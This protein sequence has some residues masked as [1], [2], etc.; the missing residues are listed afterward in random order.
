MRVISQAFQEISPADFFYRNREIAGFSNPS[1]AVFSAIRE[2][3]ENSLDATE[4]FGILPDIYI[5][6]SSTSN[7][8]VEEG[9][10]SL[11]VED[12]GIGIPGEHI[13]HAFC[14]FLFSSKYR[15]R[16][17]RG[18]FGL[19]GTMA[20]LYGQ[21][22]TN[23]PVRV[24]SSTGDQ[25]IYEF[26]LM[27]DIER[28]RPIILGKKT[29]NNDEQWHGTIV[30]IS[31]EGDYPR[32]KPKIVDY[33]KQTAIA[34]PYAN[35]MF[36]DPRGR[37]YKFERTMST[38]PPQPKETLPHPH[39]VDVET[40]HRMVRATQCKTL[41][42]FLEK[43]F[44]RVGRQTARSFLEFAGFPEDMD[45]KALKPEEIVRLVQAMRSFNGFLPPDASCLSPL[46]EEILKAGI[47]K[48]LEPEFVAVTQRKPSAY[49]GHPF[50]VEVGIAYGGK[51]PVRDDGDI[52]LYRFANKIPLV[53]DESGDVSWKVI[54]SIEWRRYGVEPGMPL[55]VIV[56]ICSTKVPWKTVGKEMIA[57]RPEISHEILYGIREV[58][59]K[60]KLY[61][62]RKEKAKHEKARLSV[63]AKYLPKI[64]E[65][66]TKLAGEK[67][68]PDIKGLLRRVRRLEGD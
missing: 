37:L 4:P 58:A 65:F 68:V 51:V 9:F 44:H 32:A 45:P 67:N 54:K 41:I 56:H 27:I 15:L 20:I 38:L 7:N 57:D 13:P 59:R 64:A 52:T 17:S 21:V 46:G 3:V 34:N 19:G 18:T 49:S 63:F 62:S 55:A 39:G 43:H 66:S 40:M 29:Y 12:N 36:V 33:L 14:Q 22:T 61:L 1:K 42:D 50:I 8:E 60:L 6:L 35:I 10:Y 48:E 2:L 30:E 31:L 28:N 24:V 5:R 47:V 23:K 53:Y 11:I 26:L 16:Q 25:K